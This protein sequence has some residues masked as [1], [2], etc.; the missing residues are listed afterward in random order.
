LT[1]LILKAL[2]VVCDTIARPNVSLASA[3]RWRSAISSDSVMSAS[4]STRPCCSLMA[5]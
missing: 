3:R 2:G 4:S 1:T 5:A